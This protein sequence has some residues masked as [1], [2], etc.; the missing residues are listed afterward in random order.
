MPGVMEAQIQLLV[1][2]VAG[3]IAVIAVAVVVVVQ[4]LLVVLVVTPDR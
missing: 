3:E 1:Q 4:V 2:V